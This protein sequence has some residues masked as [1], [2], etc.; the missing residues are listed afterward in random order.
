MGAAA[1]SQFAA[2]RPAWQ[3]CVLR[4]RDGPASVRWY[5][6][7]FGMT[8]LAHERSASRE[9]RFVLAT[10]PRSEQ[11]AVA[12]PE[13]RSAAQA[14]AS[15]RHGQSQ[16]ELVWL[17]GTEALS[18]SA[19]PVRDHVGR[20]QLFAN[21]NAEPRGFGHVAFNV[22]DVYALCAELEAQGVPFKK[23]PNEGMMKGL[24]FACDPDGYWVEIL[25]GHSVAEPGRCTLSQTML[26]VKDPAPSLAFYGALFD[27]QTVLERHFDASRGDFSL[28][29]LVTRTREVARLLEQDK[30]SVTTAMWDAALELTWN[31]GTEAQPGPSYH[32]GNDATFPGVAGTVPQGF[33]CLA[34]LVDDLSQFTQLVQRYG[35]PLLH[36]SD[37]LVVLADPTG[38]HVEVRQRSS[39]AA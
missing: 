18:D 20:S 6:R 14:A 1:A 24:A 8:L 15:P 34:F 10:L 12:A 33:K 13:S 21:G 16:L 2:L 11:A 30:S 4:A 19:L 26:R 35:V 38:Y 32:N 31:H 9:H 39:G 28:F 29:F 5:E 22:P 27:M 23:R 17:E 7:H 25:Q 3:R 36:A 37:A